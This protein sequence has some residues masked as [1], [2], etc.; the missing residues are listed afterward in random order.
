MGLLLSRSAFG[1]ARGRYVWARDSVLWQQGGWTLLRDSLPWLPEGILHY[2]D[3]NF[4]I[5]EGGRQL[6]LFDRLTGRSSD[7]PSVG[8]RSE[9]DQGSVSVAPG[10]KWIAVARATFEEYDEAVEGGPAPIESTLR[11]LRGGQFPELVV[12]ETTLRTAVRA[13]EWDASGDRLLLNSRIA[14]SD[15]RAEGVEVSVLELPSQRRYAVYQGSAVQAVGWL[16]TAVAGLA[17]A[18]AQWALLGA[19]GA[20]GAGLLVV[21]VAVTRSGIRRSRPRERG[22][23]AAALCEACG[24]RIQRSAKFC[25]KCGKKLAG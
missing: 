10:A 22:L 9:R 25:T 15:D 1:Q 2:V 8:G 12:E 14:R 17:P 11:I 23:G 21:L 24:A 6:R 16:R 20:V 13:V 3:D 7:L 5:V 4:V 18:T 19:A